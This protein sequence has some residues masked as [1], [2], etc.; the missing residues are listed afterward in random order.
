MDQGDVFCSISRCGARGADG[1][2]FHLA[3]SV[4][5]PKPLWYKDMLYPLSYKAAREVDTL[6]RES[7]AQDFCN[8][9]NG[10]AVGNRAILGLW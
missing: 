8:F 4:V 7:L 10:D 6:R 3:Q 2:A 9:C 5:L 1:D